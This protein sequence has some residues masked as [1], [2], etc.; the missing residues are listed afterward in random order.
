MTLLDKVEYLLKKNGLNKRQLSLQADIPYSTIDGWFKVGYDNMKLSTFKK[1][2]RFFDVDMTSMAFDELD[3]QPYD[4]ER[5]HTT[6]KE[7][8]LII[9]YR[10]ADEFDRTSVCRTLHIE[11]SDTLKKG[12]SA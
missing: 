1:L 3:I 12:E 6:S 2:C 8:E 4:P 5:M 7:R 11:E 9:K 10:Q